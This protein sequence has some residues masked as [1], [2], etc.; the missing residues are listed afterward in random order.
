MLS[1]KNI[2]ENSSS[3]TLTPGVHVVRI[4]SIE[5][6]PG[7]Q[8]GAYRVQLNVE[9]PDLGPDFEGF[10][11]DPN[12]Q[13]LGRY[14]GQIGRVNLSRYEYADAVTKTGIQVYR[15]RS[16]LRDLAKL[17]G[18]LNIRQELDEIQA[19]TIEEYMNKAASL[20]AGKK[21]KMV[22][23][24]KQYEKNGYIQYN[25]FIPR[26]NGNETAYVREGGDETN[27]I[28]F[29]PNVHIIKLQQ[30]SQSVD[31]FEPAP[32]DLNSEP[33]PTNGTTNALSDFMV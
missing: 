31:S 32:F 15:D 33:F 22:I 24:G 21:L 30:Q 8:A 10:F 18:A 17:A 16:I 11:I 26:T 5:L 2:T 14:K 27:L 19:D 1:T 13:N 20:F 28:N 7:F 9:G 12:N 29:D 3:K 4:N 23:A 25:L 6:V